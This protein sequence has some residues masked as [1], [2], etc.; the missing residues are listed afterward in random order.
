VHII[1]SNTASAAR[2]SQGAGDRQIMHIIKSHG[3][4]INCVLSPPVLGAGITMIKKLLTAK[5][6]KG[7]GGGGG[8]AGG[9]GLFGGEADK[10]FSS[11]NVEGKMCGTA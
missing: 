9:G 10:K 1:S 11:V 3:K 6:T 7:L 8:E 4:S 2:M 5:F